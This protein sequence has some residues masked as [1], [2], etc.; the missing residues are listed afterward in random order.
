MQTSPVLYVPELFCSLKWIAEIRRFFAL[1]WLS[2]W[3]G[4]A[5]WQLEGVVY[6]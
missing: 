5:S 3:A 4:L 1:R 6:R 2:S